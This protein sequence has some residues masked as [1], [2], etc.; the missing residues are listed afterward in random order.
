MAALLPVAS[1]RN[2]PRGARSWIACPSA[3][4]Y[5]RRLLIPIWSVALV[6]DAPIRLFAFAVQPGRLSVAE[7]DLVAARPATMGAD[8]TAP[9]AASEV[10]LS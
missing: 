7:E 2:Q 1:D 6:Q 5:R 8:R 9:L 4:P 3:A 10:R